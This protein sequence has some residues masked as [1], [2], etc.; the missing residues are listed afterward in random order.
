V[1]VQLNEFIDYSKPREAHPAPVAVARLVSDVARTLLP[2]IEEKRITLVPLESTLTIE[3]DEQL[4]RQA[5][6]NILLNAVQAVGPDGRIEVRLTQAGPREAVLE[7]DDNGPGVPEA[8]RASIFKPYVTMKQGGV[9]L[10]LAI[11]QQIV[12]AHHWTIV[13][14]TNELKGAR[15]RIGGMKLAAPTT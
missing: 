12:S 5:L 1:T 15:F 3:A 14:G 11:V 8:D 13:C 10:G 6:F 7:I 9:G 4:L 2:D